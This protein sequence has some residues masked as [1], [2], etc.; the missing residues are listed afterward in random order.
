MAGKKKEGCLGCSQP[1]T[2]QD[3]AIQCVICGL[4]SH[5]KCGKIADEFVSFLQQQIEATGSA[6]WACKPCVAYSQGITQK[7]RG[8][9]REVEQIKQDVK[10]NAEGVKK[11][12]TEVQE[13]KRKVDNNNQN[14]EEAIRASEQRMTGEWREREIRRKNLVVHR[15]PE[16]EEAVRG[17]EARRDFD[18]E[19][20]GEIL[21]AIGLG[22][23]KSEI[24]ACRR[25]GERG[26]EPRPLLLV[27]R[28]EE[29]KRRILDEARRL[30]S[31][32]YREVGIVPDLTAGQRK[33]EEDMRKEVDRRNREELSQ[34]D[35]AKN[36]V[37]TLVGP[38]GEKR[39]IK[40]VRRE[41]QGGARGTRYDQGWTYR[42]NRQQQQERNSGKRTRGRSGDGEEENP[43]K[44]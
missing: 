31:T 14:I 36:L 22:D 8:I 1:F 24:K 38:R 34:E 44:R 32:N 41:E 4:W 12:E 13:I 11:I 39:M 5:Q 21:R 9:E 29:N 15:V 10:G 37:W 27:M 2:K 43:A 16:A 7:I 30:V 35:Q 33:E 42:H 17:W 28:T 25:I 26:E 3:T 40:T 23:L 6:Y 18:M 20:S 19:R